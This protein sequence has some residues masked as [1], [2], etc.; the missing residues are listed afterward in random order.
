MTHM[1]RV[2]TILDVNQEAPSI[3][4]NFKPPANWPA[5]GAVQFA[6]Y[7]TRYRSHLQPV[8]MNISMTIRPGEKIGIVGRTGAG[9]SSL[10]MA[11]M[12]GLEADEGKIIIDGLDIV[13]LGLRDLREAIA[14][15]PQ[16]PTLF[17]GTIRTTL[18]P[19]SLYTDEEILCALRRV[20]LIDSP[21]RDSTSSTLVEA[22]A[23]STFQ[24][25][26]SSTRAN[27][28]PELYPPSGQT[29]PHQNLNLFVNLSTPVTSSG[30]NISLGQRQLLCL[31]RVL[32][33]A[34]RILIMDEATASI[35]S[36]TDTRIQSTIRALSR[37]LKT[38]ILTIAHRLQ[39]VIDYDRILVLDKGEVVEF[40]APATLLRREGGV[41]KDMCEMSGDL[42]GLRWDADEAERGRKLIDV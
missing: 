11:L 23:P 4:A 37:D 35:D 21:S 41:F 15:V 27:Q 5:E 24:R 25:S 42:E 8:L 30:S 10:A 19:F 14:F 6:D 16:D 31:A 40:D 34:P 2:K 22:D 1:E 9:K 36:V 3:N 29:R 20:H 17:T 18:D 7:T 26:S 33:K 38:T 32:L 39:T 13:Q 28:N 12:R